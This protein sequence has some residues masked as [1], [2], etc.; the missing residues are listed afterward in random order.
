V[1]HVYQCSSGKQD[2]VAFDNDSCPI[3]SKYAHI[4]RVY[5]CFNTE[6]SEKPVGHRSDG[7]LCNKLDGVGK[8]KYIKNQSS[9]NVLSPTM[10]FII[11][12]IIF[13]SVRFR[14]WGRVWCS[15]IY[16]RVLILIANLWA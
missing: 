12:I 8:K 6:L 1:Y 3:L 2:S 13:G 10:L 5:Q 15:W 11:I 7:R 4:S 14:F 9:D 16:V